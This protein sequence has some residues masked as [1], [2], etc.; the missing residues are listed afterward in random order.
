MNA[1]HTASSQIWGA[2]INYKIKK[3]V[4]FILRM[5]H[6]IKGSLRCIR[7]RGTLGECSSWELRVRPS[8]CVAASVDPEF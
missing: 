4:T 6:H 1:A 7:S 5:T 8:S 3:S 2:S